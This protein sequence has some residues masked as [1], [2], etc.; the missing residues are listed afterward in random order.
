MD[1]RPWILDLGIT[2][3]DFRLSEPSV[4]HYQLSI[5]HYLHLQK[6]AEDLGY[7]LIL[8]QETVVA[9]V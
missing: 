5:N 3:W 2:I 6:G 1:Y 7:L 8:N 9:V 4:I